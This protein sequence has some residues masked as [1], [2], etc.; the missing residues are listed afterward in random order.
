MS[1][2]L[3]LASDGEYRTGTETVTFG[4]RPGPC[5]ESV[6]LT[7]RPIASGRRSAKRVHSGSLRSSYGSGQDGELTGEHFHGGNDLTRSYAEYGA[8]LVDVQ[9]RQL[10]GL[11]PSTT[12]RLESRASQEVCEIGARRTDVGKA[13]A[14]GPV[15]FAVAHGQA[16]TE[17]LVLPI[18]TSSIV[19]TYTSTSGFGWLPMCQQTPA[20]KP[21]R[22]NRTR[23]LTTRTTSRHCSQTK[24]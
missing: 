3:S 7:P 12:R 22:R 16:P 1:S 10:S 11:T 6:T 5:S 17:L 15:R 2:C 14:P 23:W 24:V 19:G 8:P 4:R 20:T 18:A 21:D 9:S 13:L